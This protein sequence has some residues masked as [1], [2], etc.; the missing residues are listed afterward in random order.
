MS[1]ILN[2][3]I[4]QNLETKFSNEASSWK[5]EN[6]FGADIV[7]IPPGHVLDFFGYLKSSGTFDL[8]MD[9]TAVDYPGR[10][11][12]FEVVYGEAA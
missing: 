12:R 10:E 2:T 11:K 7:T 9:V 4:K 1:K 8:L 5:W 6:S 3:D